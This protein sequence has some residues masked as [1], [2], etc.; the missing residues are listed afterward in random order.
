[1][2]EDDRQLLARVHVPCTGRCAG[3]YLSGAAVLGGLVLSSLL[4]L[5]HASAGVPAAWTHRDD[6][7][8][9]LDSAGLRQALALTR[10]L[11]A[12]EV[13]EI[14]T[15]PYVRCQFT[16]GPVASIRQLPVIVCPWLS[17]DSSLESVSNGVQ[18]L[19]GS[20][21]LCTHREVLP[22]MAAELVARYPQLDCDALA[23][24]AKGAGYWV[25]FDDGK[26]IEHRY[27]TPPQADTRPQYVGE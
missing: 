2:D 15:S 22:K 20:P 11:Q 6:R 13:D 7:T 26:P 25:R 23:N 19:Q 27:L 4:V 18:T 5:R 9:P 8:R 1:M 16:V 12:V 10:T 17:A 21:L 3:W 24:L 14:L